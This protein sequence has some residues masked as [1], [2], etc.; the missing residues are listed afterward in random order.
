MRYTYIRK[1]LKRQIDCN[2]KQLWTFNEKTQTF[3]SLYSIVDD[4]LTIYTPSQLLD[5]LN[6][7]IKED[8]NTT[9]DKAEAVDS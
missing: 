5:R 9:K 6:K 8:A 2:I 3:T 7:I 1:E 4:S